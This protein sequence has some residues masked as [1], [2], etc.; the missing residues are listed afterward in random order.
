MSLIVGHFLWTFPYFKNLFTLL[1]YYGGGTG[2]LLMVNDMNDAE[3]RALEVLE[4]L[5][6]TVICILYRFCVFCKAELVCSTEIL[7]TDSKVHFN[8]WNTLISNM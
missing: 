1:C 4:F 8:Q 7:C 6:R 5:S 3:T 2:A